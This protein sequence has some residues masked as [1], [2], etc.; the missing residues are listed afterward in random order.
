VVQ[1]V[2]ILVPRSAIESIVVEP[3][4]DTAKTPPKEEWP[5]ELLDAARAITQIDSEIFVFGGFPKVDGF[6]ALSEARWRWILACQFDHALRAWEPTL[7]TAERAERGR[8]G[9]RV[10]AGSPSPH[11]LI[12][13]IYGVADAKEAESAWLDGVWLWPDEVSQESAADQIWLLDEDGGA[14]LTARSAREKRA[15]LQGEM[16]KIAIKRRTK[17]GEFVPF[18]KLRNPS[19][20]RKRSRLRNAINEPQLL[21]QARLGLPHLN[22]ELWVRYVFLSA[23]QDSAPGEHSAREWASKQLG[24]MIPRSRSKTVQYDALGVCLV[25]AATYRWI[26]RTRELEGKSPKTKILLDVNG[27]SASDAACEI[28]P[29]LLRSINYVNSPSPRTIRRI[30]ES[31]QYIKAMQTPNER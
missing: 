12:K 19:Q 18:R 3:R 23:R 24:R 9:R 13:T 7:Y 30:I 20:L 17:T 21:R 25:F 14:N 26:K 10:P 2:P 28:T 8:G 16:L 29:Q 4:M 22:P 31:S 11:E 1:P 5:R 15:G 27:M 6:K